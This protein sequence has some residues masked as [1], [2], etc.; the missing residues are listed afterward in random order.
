MTAV[1][2]RLKWWPL[3]LILAASVAGFLVLVVT[4]DSGTAQARRDPARHPQPHTKWRGQIAVAVPTD[5]SAPTLVE[6]ATPEHR[7]PT[8]IYRAPK[9]ENVMPRDLKDTKVIDCLSRHAGSP[10]GLEE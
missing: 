6:V 7:A 3:W 5:T 10:S 4:D 1:R 8:V 2:A 9:Y